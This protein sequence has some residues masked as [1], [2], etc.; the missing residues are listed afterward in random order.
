M[1]IREAY[2]AICS[3]GDYYS[4]QHAECVMVKCKCE[5]HWEVNNNGNASNRPRN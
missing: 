5:C 4:D 2:S 1:R 3:T